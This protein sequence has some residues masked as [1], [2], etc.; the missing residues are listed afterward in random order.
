MHGSGAWAEQDT[1]SSHFLQ[2]PSLL[3]SSTNDQ[4]ILLFL[5]R[6][7]IQ[8]VD[9]RH[10]VTDSVAYGSRRLRLKRR[11]RRVVVRYLHTVF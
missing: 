11:Q 1:A 9:R 3:P 8:G 2:R 4:C 7:I 6:A 10:S 5:S